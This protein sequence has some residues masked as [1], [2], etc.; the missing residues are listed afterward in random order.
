[1]SKVY[2]LIRDN[3]DDYDDRPTVCGVFDD[4]NKLTKWAEECLDETQEWSWLYH[5]EDFFVEEY[6]TTTGERTKEEYKLFN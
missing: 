2:V 3:K 6:E 1:M 4:K 5:R